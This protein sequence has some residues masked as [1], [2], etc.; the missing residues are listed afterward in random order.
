MHCYAYEITPPRVCSPL[1]AITTYS[2]RWSITCSF[3]FLSTRAVHLAASEKNTRAVVH[4]KLGLLPS[5]LEPLPSSHHQTH[6]F[7]PHLRD[8]K[9][10]VLIIKELLTLCFIFSRGIVNTSKFNLSIQVF[11]VKRCRWSHIVP[12]IL[13]RPQRA[14]V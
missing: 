11:I 12:A 13:L 3:F 5:L 6:T 1:L 7:P 14:V 4:W 8:L 10:Q 2:C 9:N